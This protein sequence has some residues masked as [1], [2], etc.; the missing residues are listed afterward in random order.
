MPTLI[1]AQMRGRLWTRWSHRF[2][3]T[4]LG[5]QRVLTTS[6]LLSDVFLDTGGGGGADG[7]YVAPGRSADRRLLRGRGVGKKAS[8]GGVIPPP[9]K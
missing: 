4:L 3:G 2:S 5:K 7:D 8:G 9:A 1:S 6:G